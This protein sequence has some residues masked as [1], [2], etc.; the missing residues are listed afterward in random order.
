MINV[1]Q[2]KPNILLV[3][4]RT[5][6]FD[7]AVHTVINLEDRLIIHLKTDD[8][9][10]GDP[11]VGR[12]VLCFDKSGDMLWRIEDTEMTIGEGED[13]VPQSFLSL[14]F[15]DEKIVVSNPDAIF[16]VNPEN[17]MLYDGEPKYQ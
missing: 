8:F 1:Q 7:Q 4:G 15:L 17:G 6:T 11:L 16:L 13:E 14:E 3:N 12:N 5:L 9:Q 10:R 2:P